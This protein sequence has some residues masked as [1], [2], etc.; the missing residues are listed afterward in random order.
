MIVMLAQGAEQNLCH[1]CEMFKLSNQAQR[2]EGPG[3]GRADVC[4]I[5]STYIHVYSL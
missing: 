4:V 1:G 3:D 2:W 5:M